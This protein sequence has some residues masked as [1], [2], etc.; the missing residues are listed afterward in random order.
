MSLPFG[1]EHVPSS[2]V[3]VT[4]RGRRQQWYRGGNRRRQDHGTASNSYPRCSQNERPH[5][6]AAKR[7]ATSDSIGENKITAEFELNLEPFGIEIDEDLQVAWDRQATRE[8]KTRHT[9]KPSYDEGDD[10]DA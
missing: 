2:S 10:F 6:S 1:F 7:F 9:R 8:L 4:R 3:R 5:R